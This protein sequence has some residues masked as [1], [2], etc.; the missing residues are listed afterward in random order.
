MSSFQPVSESVVIN[1]Q[2]GVQGPQGPPG[3]TGATG[4]TGPEGATGP[5]G[6]QGPAGSIPSYK[7]T[8]GDGTTKT[9]TVTHNLNDLDVM[10]T[11]IDGTLQQIVY[12]T[13]GAG[14]NVNSVTLTFSVAPTT[15][16]MR[17]IVGGF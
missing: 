17:V 2:T 3:P 6:P 14:V 4:A 10:V 13:I 8:L 9:F 7:T 1:T 11:V 5:Q 12:P 15:N 16:Q